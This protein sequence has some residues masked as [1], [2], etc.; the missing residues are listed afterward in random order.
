M[1]LQSL[2]LSPVYATWGVDATL[3][4]A[5]GGPVTVRVL[6]RTSGV[7]VAS[8]S[9]TEILTIRPAALV[10]VSELEASGVQRDELRKAELAMNGKTW[11]IEASL[12]KP[13]PNGE[14]DGELMLILIE[15]D[16]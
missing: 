3:C 4:P 6:D 14:S 15:T 12:P 9:N 1:D 2:V 5:L 7:E 13:T 16:E 10:R 11:R 8:A